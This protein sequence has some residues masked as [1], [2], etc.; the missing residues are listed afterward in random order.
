[1]PRIPKTPYL[2]RINLKTGVRN[3]RYSPNLNLIERLWKFV[4]KECL[5]SIH[6]PNYEAFT[7]AI[8]RCLEDLP[9]KYKADMDSLLAH[10]F[11]TFENVS[12]LAA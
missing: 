7:T 10:N 1:M 8:T 6:Y 2:I 4:K 5:R 11:Q 9:T 12:I 3:V